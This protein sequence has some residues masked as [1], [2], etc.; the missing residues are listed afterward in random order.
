[1]TQAQAPNTRAWIIWTVGVLAY[2]LSVANRSSL[3][4]VGV[5]AADRFQAD[6][7]TLSMFAVLQLAVYALMQIPVGILLDRHGARP[8]MTIGMALMA[9]GQ[10]VMAFSPNVGV[11]IA[12]RMLLGAGDAALFP[13]VLR[14]VSTWYS[15][16][17]AP[18][19]AQLTGT[20]G[21]AGQLLSLVPLPALLHATSWE[22]AF[23]ALA[24]TGILFTILVF[25]IIR[26]RPPG[27]TQDVSVN[28]DTGAIRVVRSSFDLR[29]PIREAWRSPGTRLGF[30]SHFTTPFAG[31]SFVMLW[32][33]PF[34]TGGE[35]QSRELASLIMVFFVLCAMA[36]GPVLGTLSGRHP[37]RR[38]YGLVL[39]AVA[40]QFVAWMAV[41]LWPGEAPVWLLFV[42]A[43]ALATGGPAS[44][45]AFDHARAHNPQHRLSTATGV[46]NGGGFISALL[47]IFL[48]GTVLDLQ[49]AGSPS[50]YTLEAF[51]WAFL[52]QIPLW[53]L[54]SFFIV[55][56][57][58]AVRDVL[59]IPRKGRPAPSVDDED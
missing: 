49:G 32:G 35:G 14:V 48:I 16:Q 11:A 28:T 37:L 9:I 15:A 24:G 50:T 34:L 8:I 55:R 43:F 13:G 56:E 17:R 31:T 18:L 10:L 6:A 41:I 22:I 4:A 23:G 59:G 36:L 57:R 44:M 1:M 12:A 3:S 53:A 2:V 38:S 39:P 47:L 51:R 30:W 7:S 54:G 5:D 19:M 26:N 42:L 45:I 46:V 33:V 52:A 29:L 27:V 21:Q 20:V 58:R 25:F 40:V